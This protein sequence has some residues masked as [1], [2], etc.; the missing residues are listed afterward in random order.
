MEINGVAHVMLTAG[1]FEK[2]AAFYRELLPF[3]GMT[4]VMDSD[5]LLYGVGARTAIGVQPP[6]KEHKG[7]KFVQKRIGLHHLC[8]RAKTRE[9]VD[10][11]HDWLIANGAKIVHPPEEGSWA[12]GYYSVLFEDPDG[13]RLEINHVPGKGLFDA[14]GK[15]EKYE[16]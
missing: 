7:E 5:V 4:L 6:D 14:G 2:S 1:D 8:F 11:A 16:Q 9:S 15:L 12:P 3:L 10:E 13:V